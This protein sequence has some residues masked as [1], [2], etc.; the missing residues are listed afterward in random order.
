VFSTLDNRRDPHSGIFIKAS[1]DFAGVGGDNHFVKSIGDLRA[2]REILP[3]SDIIGMVRL[4]G[5]NITGLG[6]NVPVPVNFAYGGDLVRGFA[7]YG[8]GPRGATT[9]ISYGGKNFAVATAEVQ[10]P[11]PI[12]PDDFGL[13]GA[14]FADAGSVWGLDPVTVSEAIN[15]TGFALRASAGFSILWASPFGLLRGDFGF[16]ITKASSD[17]TQVFR[18]SA[19]TQF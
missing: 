11:M 10:F 8:I 6:Q 2:Y 13:R 19:G 5:G 1:Q 18:F 16:P 15:S 12:V 4:G 14:F 7:N 17:Q 3:Q 9:G